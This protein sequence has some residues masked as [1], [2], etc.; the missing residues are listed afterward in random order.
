M[1]I[2]NK[3][4]FAVLNNFIKFKQLYTKYQFLLQSGNF[5]KMNTS[6]INS[7]GIGTTIHGQHP[8]WNFQQNPQPSFGP[9]PDGV[10]KLVTKKKIDKS[11]KYSFFPK[12]N[13]LLQA[14]Y[15]ST[16]N[17]QFVGLL[18]HILRP[19]TTPSG[20]KPRVCPCMMCLCTRVLYTQCVCVYMCTRD[21][22][23]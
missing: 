14:T 20:E 4:L 22:T 7:C 9:P 15:F 3:L 6:C 18:T 5:Y 21:N 19:F 1:I 2:P 8:R 13:M 17:P 11:K 16:I 10:E 12:I 23:R